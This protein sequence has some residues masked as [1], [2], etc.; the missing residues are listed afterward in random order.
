MKLRA[1]DEHGYPVDHGSVRFRKLAVVT[2]IPKP[3]DVYPLT[4]ASGLVLPSTVVRA[5]WNDARGLFVVAYQYANRSISTDEYNALVNDP[6]WQ[7]T[8]LI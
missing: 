2:T 4:T 8:P 7:M 3:G 5:D 6:D 1:L